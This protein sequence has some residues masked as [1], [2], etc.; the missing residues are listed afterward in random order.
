M[1]MIRSR[2]WLCLMVLAVAGCGGKKPAT[3]ATGDKETPKPAAAIFASSPVDWAAL[4]YE[5]PKVKA[6]LKPYQVKPDLSNVA[7]IGDFK[8]LTKAQRAMLAKNGFLVLPGVDKQLF[9]VYENNDYKQVPS[10]VACDAVLQLYHIFYDYSLRLVEGAH[11]VGLC[12]KLSRHMYDDQLRRWKQETDPKIKSALLKNVAFFGVALTA[13]GEKPKLPAGADRIV[14][15]EMALIKEH[16]GRKKS[17]IFPYK[18]DYSQFAPRGHYTRSEMLKQ[19]FVAM[20]WYGLVPLPLEYEDLDSGKLVPADEQ[21]RQSI[22][23]VDAL[24]TTE[25]GGKPAIEVWDR[26]YEPTAF[27]V[28][29][30]DDFTPSE[31]L[32]F[33]R[34]IFGD[35]GI[36]ATLDSA[37]LDRFVARVKRDRRPRIADDYVIG[38]PT[39]QQFRFMGQRQ[40]P[41]S[42][43]F[44]QMVFGRV[45]V[46]EKRRLFPRGLDVF[47]ALGSKRA[48]QILDKVYHEPEYVNY[49]KQLNKLKAEF[50]AFPDEQWRANLY[51]GWLWSLRSVVEPVG[52]GYPS[53]MRNNAWLDKSLNT[54]L[55]SWAE[56][57]HDT[58]LYAKQSVTSECGDGEEP[59]PPPKGYVEPNPHLYS[60]LIWL[61]EAT[62]KGLKERGLL[63]RELESASSGMDSLL[64]FLLHISLKELADEP[65]RREDYEQIRLIGATLENLDNRFTAAIG[66]K[67]GGL[68]SE[69]D[70][71]MAVVADVHTAFPECLEEGVGHA[72][73]IYA[74]VPIEGKL[75]LTR[76]S[77]FSYYEFTWPVSDRLTDE[78]WQEILGTAE[79]PKRP[80]W[81]KSFLGTGKFEPTPRHPA[82]STGC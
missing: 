27:Y 64:R 16:K 14:A 71:D 23:M 49:N 75:Y 52:E 78:A 40:I 3:R 38:I 59:P 26:I 79:E 73:H 7:N 36:E 8:R 44:Q 82:R 31:W 67:A 60:R 20:M 77:V 42:Y 1:K 69:A 43:M 63:P 30:A 29:T 13:L 66:G 65:L 21:I 9:F 19:Y 24:H 10:F 37:A 32:A 33:R 45:G 72:D 28:E 56:L 6:R 35:A 74:V 11:L 80:I 22:L 61:N 18:I 51:W 25:I 57:R 15:A 62:Q 12:R 41:D 70:E 2:W 17:A 54:A 53:F 81:T 76:G 5:A 50:A 46:P 55:A 4:P 68:I 48:Y 34:E 39:G 47:A 58:I